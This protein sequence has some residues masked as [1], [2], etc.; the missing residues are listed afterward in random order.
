M[1]ISDLH[2]IDISSWQN[3]IT[4]AALNKVD[5]AIFKIAEGQ[6]WTDPCFDEFYALAKIPVGAYVF[7]HAVTEDAARREAK[8]AVELLKGRKLPLG[9]YIDVED[10]AQLALSD[11][12]LTA[13]VKAFCDEVKAAGYIAGAYGSGGQLWAKVGPSYVGDDVIVWA[14]SWGM[15]PKI[16]CDVWQY[17]DHA[18][19]DGYNAPVDGDEALSERFIAMVNGEAQPD[20]TPAEPDPEPDAPTVDTFT[21]SGVPVLMHGDTGDA[22]KALQGELIAQG[23][24]CGGKRDWRGAETPDGIFGNFTQEAV[25]SFQRKRNLPVTGIAEHDT[26]K[27]LLGVV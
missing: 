25:R 20:P 6:T 18:R 7:S 26:R 21:I 24:N 27:A 2:G 10:G 4:A 19:I 22:V 16:S 17:T 15:K 3:G 9:L 23:Y 12:A 5:F 1:N 11:S 8:R 14:A 13:V